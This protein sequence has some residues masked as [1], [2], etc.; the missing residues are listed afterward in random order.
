MRKYETIWEQVKIASLDPERWVV[1]TVK[2]EPMIQTIIDRVQGE[3]SRQQV[4]R[5]ALDLPRFGKL[6][7]RREPLRVSFRITNSGDVL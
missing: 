1:V 7:I 2:S 4:A 5:R 6:Q 3:K